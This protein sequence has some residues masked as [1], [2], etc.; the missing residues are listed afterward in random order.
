MAEIIEFHVPRQVPED[1]NEV[2]SLGKPPRIRR[3]C[4]LS[5]E[6]AFVRS[7]KFFPPTMTS[8]QSGSRFRK[9]GQLPED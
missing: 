8:L 4:F 6:K 1:S 5:E 9:W 2:V 3:F 7:S